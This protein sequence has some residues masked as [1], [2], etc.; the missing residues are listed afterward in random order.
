MNGFDILFDV[1]NRDAWSLRRR[2]ACCSPDHLKAHPVYREGPP[3]RV[4][5]GGP[6]PECPGLPGGPL[7]ARVRGA[8]GAR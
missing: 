7:G 8:P 6:S 5:E 1:F 2:C 4:D 3:D